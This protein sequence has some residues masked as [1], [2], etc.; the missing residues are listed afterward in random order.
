MRIMLIFLLSSCFGC[1]K[2]SSSGDEDLD[3]TADFLFHCVQSVKKRYDKPSEI[4]EY[5]TSTIGKASLIPPNTDIP[6]SGP[7]P[8]D[9]TMFFGEYN[10]ENFLEKQIVLYG[11]DERGIIVAEGYSSNES[12]DPDYTWEWK[13]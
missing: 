4:A 5:I 2:V 12:E 9:N 3:K 13:L 6:Y 11:D 8:A 1:T 7:R 10:D